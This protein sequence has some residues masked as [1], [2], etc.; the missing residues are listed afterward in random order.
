MGKQKRRELTEAWEAFLVADETLDHVD[1]IRRVR[2]AAEDAELDAVR[3]ARAQGI[4]W[5]RIGALYGLT[6]QGAQ[7]R[8]R[9]KG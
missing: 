2:E 4:S 9:L 1:A 8:F 3:T 6:K 7:Q 5:S